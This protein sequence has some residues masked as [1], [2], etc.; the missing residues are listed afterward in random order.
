VRLQMPTLDLHH[1]GIWPTI[2]IVLT[3]V[4]FT[5]ACFVF[6]PLR[7][8]PE[9]G[10]KVQQEAASPGKDQQQAAT[11]SKAEFSY[12]GMSVGFF[13]AAGYPTAPG[14]YRY[15]PYRGGGHYEMQ[16]ALKA[17]SRPRCSF[18]TDKRV[19]SFAVIA[20]PEYGVLELVE[21]RNEDGG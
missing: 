21:F 13:E 18:R 6:G 16:T 4:A 20:C 8:V 14:R 15:M 17:G 12:K 5:A 10:K 9:R 11:T 7:E 1:K 3:V 2:L 19:V